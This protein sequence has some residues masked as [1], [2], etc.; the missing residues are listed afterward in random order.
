MKTG[1]AADPN[2]GR[3]DLFEFIGQDNVDRL[4]MNVPNKLLEALRTLDSWRK[5]ELVLLNKGK[6]DTKSQKSFEQYT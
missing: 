2:G 3:A 6:G 1:K 4:I 5:N